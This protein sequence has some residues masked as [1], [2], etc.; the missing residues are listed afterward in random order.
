MLLRTI[1]HVV[2]DWSVGCVFASLFRLGLRC[3]LDA[4]NQK[5]YSRKGASGFDLELSLTAPP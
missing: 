2:K 5:H 1:T 4:N 3:T